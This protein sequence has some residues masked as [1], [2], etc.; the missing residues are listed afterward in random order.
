MGE[1]P[2]TLVAVA[3]YNEIDNLPRLV[4]EVFRQA[5]QVDILVVDDNS[6]DGTGRWC[7]ARALQEPR[8]HVL[9]RAAKL[10]LGS[11]TRAAIRYAI[12]Q[13]YTRLLTLDADFSHSP[14][15]VPELLARLEA[16]DGHQADVVIGSRYVRGGGIRGWPLGRRLMS[17]LLNFATRWLLDLPV[18]DCSGGFRCFRVATL[19][20]VDW[21]AAGAQGYAFL[22]EM[23]W[24]L[25]RHG[26][27]FA[28]V[29]IQFLDRQ[30]GR[31][32]ISF[33]EAAAAAFTILRLG[34]RNWLW[35]R[36][37]GHGGG[38][39]PPSAAGSPPCSR[40]S[41]PSQGE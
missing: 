33:R 5:P 36:P 40:T 15:H 18:R 17:R 39:N 7:D 10:G 6:P 34:V 1:T 31:S 2:R 20:R 16:A 35:R 12:D 9:H 24:H 29:P 23:L 38:A 41:P 37:P 11:A 4:D 19:Q 32:K 3:T 22:E 14:R 21:D 8:F 25:H 26:A 30:K 13:G 28:E 27:R